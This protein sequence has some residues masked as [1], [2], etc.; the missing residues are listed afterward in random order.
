MIFWGKWVWGEVVDDLKKKNKI[1]G[2]IKGLDKGIGLVGPHLGLWHFEIKFGMEI[3]IHTGPDNSSLGVK[4]QCYNGSF[5]H[6]LL[7]NLRNRQ[8][9]RLQEFISSCCSF[10]AT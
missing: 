7:D 4:K 8:G 3:K 5:S 2:K 9:F 6:G 10:L 1:T